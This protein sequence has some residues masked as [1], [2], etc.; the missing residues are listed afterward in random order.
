MANKKS[1]RALGMGAEITRRDFL[2]GVAVA[3]GGT[4]IPTLAGGAAVSAQE[5]SSRPPMSAQ[6]VAPSDYPPM[7]T[8]MRGQTDSAKDAG[9]SVRDGKASSA[10][11]DTGE[12]YDLVVVG[13]GMAGL[14]AAYFYRKQIP[15]ARVLVIEACPDF[16]GHAVRNEF[17][18]D[19]KRLIAGG[20][21]YALWRP[22]TFPPEAQEL[23]RDVG[24][25]RA[26]YEKQV[27]ETPDPTKELGLGQAMFFDK[28][29]FGKDQLVMDPPPEMGL[30]RFGG[31]G[32][33]TSA[34]EFASFFA[35]TPYSTGTREGLTK[36]FTEHRD[37]MADIPTG[38]KVAQLKKMSYIDFVS[39][40]VKIHPDAVAYVLSV[41]ATGATNQTA[42]SDTFSAW[43]AWRR[44]LPGFQGM[45]L[46]PAS[47]LSNLVKDPG[48]NIR[49]PD[50]A[51]TGARLLVRWL[52]PDALPGS[53]MDDAIL[54]HIDY[55]ALDRPTNDVRIRLSSTA[56]RARHL[57]DPM[58][59]KEVEVT[60][61]RD[62]RPHNVRSRGVVMACFNAI[63]PYL[64]PDLPEPQKAALH[65]AVRK[66]LVTTNV[67]VRN[68]RAFEKLGISSVSCPGK[69]FSSIS[70]DFSPAIG[71]Y[72][73]PTTPDEPIVLY[74]RLSE[75]IL[76]KA[77]SGLPPREQWKVSRAELENIPFETFER[78]IREQLNQVLGAGVFD[79]ERDVAGIIVNRWGHGYAPG[80]NEL[81]D[82]D[83]SHRMDAP[84]V[85]GRQQF[86]RIT[87]SNSDAAW[88]SLTN[89]AW[90]QSHRAVT[91]LVTNVHRPVFD[92]QWSERDTAGE[93]GDFPNNF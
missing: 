25:D 85:V 91:E 16:G 33:T 39:N 90:Q 50:N 73:T 47:Q 9:H 81:Y 7:I 18:V 40:V 31:R 58:T 69:F 8:G 46:P 49:F 64:V 45:D 56:I 93:P 38:E 82:P 27:A 61:M 36:L 23:L 34:E 11:V 63:V 89:A 20:G 5:A 76:E 2:D 79:A 44:G 51:A 87:I 10:P 55:S 3:V 66:P 4:M 59:A 35:Q 17:M 22:N 77:G 65:L 78:N 24:I 75:R 54:Q 19:G 14:G 72:Q 67:A 26:H 53:T 68:W 70:P 15:G 13:A 84:W 6:Q 62:G 32:R 48:M 37:W 92:F 43:Y 83:Y 60:Y 74:L 52:I 1:D 57:G 71:G 86:G 41:G 88:V 12:F 21:T 42:G 29:S 28:D 80:S 30:W